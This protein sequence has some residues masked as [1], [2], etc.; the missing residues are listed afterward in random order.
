M[1]ETI[2]PFFGF[3]AIGMLVTLG[4]SAAVFPA[5]VAIGL[6]AAFASLSERPG[7]ARLARSFSWL[8]RGLPELLVIF[9][10]YF[11]SSIL[12]Q[13]L[14]GMSGL[15]LPSLTPFLAAFIAL[16]L[17]F[18]AYAGVVFVD[19][20]RVFPRGLVEAGAAVGMT[21]GRI[22]RRIVIPIL[23]RQA[24]PSLGNLFLVLLKIS[25]LASLIGVE[26]LSRRTGIIAG[27]T[28]DPLT[29]YAVAAVLYLCI[30]GAAGLLQAEVER[31]ARKFA[32]A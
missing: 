26:E 16:A 1:Y 13:K 32:R 27:S 29:C 8:F 6:A 15:R 25:A 11:G 12:L 10:V 9:A 18:G 22:R 17:Q 7:I 5:A 23:L 4:L 30:S 21:R 24:T 14:N 28:R 2:A 31:Q 19:W 20:L 3:W